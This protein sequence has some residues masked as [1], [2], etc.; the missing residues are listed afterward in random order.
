MSIEQ[1]EIQNVGL[2]IATDGIRLA[3]GWLRRAVAPIHIVSD[4]NNGLSPGECEQKIWGIY[5]RA[6]VLY[7]APIRV[8]DIQPINITDGAFQIYELVHNQRRE[9]LPGIFVG[10]VD[11]GVGSE[12]RGIVVTTNESYTFVGPDNG[13]FYPS[14]ATLTVKAAY[15]IGDE[16]FADSSVTFHGRDQFT[17]I[18]ADIATGKDPSILP[19]LERIDPRTLV[20]K[21]FIEGQVVHRDGYWNLKLWQK[22]VPIEEGQRAK[23][24]IIPAPVLFRD[25]ALWF[26]SLSIP[27]VE[28][29]GDVPVGH[30]LALEGSSC[31]NAPWE[32]DK[33]GLVDLFIR[34]RTE[35][36]GAGAKL[37]ANTGDVLKLSW[38]F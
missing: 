23:K 4:F 6:G 35:K 38:E 28:G 13:L 24:L 5:Y 29:I 30:W 27:V 21:E 10:V 25:R 19:Q 14:L 3:E 31:G 26:H 22:G 8:S 20:R 9:G 34:D 15:K 1:R 11:P 37:G 2:N 12:R 33:R 16:A 17:P 32:E 18:A 7:E 36:N